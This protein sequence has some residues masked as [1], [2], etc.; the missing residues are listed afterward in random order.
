M[1][2]QNEEVLATLSIFKL[3]LHQIRTFRMLLFIFQTNVEINF[4]DREN[5][6]LP[7]TCVKKGA[8]EC[9]Q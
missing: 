7:A 5:N 2:R 1:Q 8:F 6:Q 9:L 3:L 4:L